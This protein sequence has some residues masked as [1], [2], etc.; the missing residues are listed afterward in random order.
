MS[1]FSATLLFYQALLFFFLEYT[2]GGC[3]P[4]K[5]STGNCVCDF[6]SYTVDKLQNP[7]QTPKSSIYRR[8]VFVDS[9]SEGINKLFDGSISSPFPDL[10]SALEMESKESLQYLSTE[11]EFLLL[12][13]NHTLQPNGGFNTNFTRIELFRRNFAA[14]TLRPCY[15]TEFNVSNCHATEFKPTIKTPPYT[16][17]F[18]VSRSLLI[19]N[20]TF[21]GFSICPDSIS[22]PTSTDSLYCFNR[23]LLS[24]SSYN[25][26]A[27]FNLEAIFDAP[28]DF[29]QNA[30]I[31]K[32][33]QCQFNKILAL[34]AQT[35]QSQLYT[36]A[37]LIGTRNPWGAFV[38]ISD[39][40]FLGGCYT[41]GFF[42]HASDLP[43]LYID[44]STEFIDQKT[45]LLYQTLSLN[46]SLAGNAFS[47][48]NY[49]Q[50]SNF[51]QIFISSQTFQTAVLSTQSYK[52]SFG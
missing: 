17:F 33:S 42:N 45:R 40:V 43:S 47:F 36:Y 25:F 16:I 41:A 1:F 29:Q 51:T 32:I 21:L 49:D 26:E 13:P 30:P 37:S 38:D 50:F 18:Y 8:Q 39:S 3:L 24:D 7:C 5:I 27:L 6:F 15:C 31:L 23:S 10:T 28:P 11:I 22:A 34:G 52:I 4:S 9:S 20:I 44:I 35:S 48:Y 19:Q 46:F 14:I 2:K 12:S